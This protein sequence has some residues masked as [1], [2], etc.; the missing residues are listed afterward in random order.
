MVIS[1]YRVPK[2]VNFIIILILYD[3]VFLAFQT[4]LVFP[5]L[6]TG[7]MKEH[8]TESHKFYPERWLKKEY[9]IHPYAS[10]PYGHGARMCLGRRFA[11]LEMQILLAKVILSFNYSIFLLTNFVL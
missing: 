3:R 8:V 1:G 7:N 10:L 6:I 4:Q 9:Y 2:G 5:T 11:D